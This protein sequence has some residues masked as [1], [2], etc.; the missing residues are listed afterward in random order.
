VQQ[1]D[2]TGSVLLAYIEGDLEPPDF[3]HVEALVAALHASDQ[4]SVSPPE[5]VNEGADDYRTL[6]LV[7]RLPA[8]SDRVDREL[9]AL[10]D[11]ER[12]VAVVEG[13]TISWAAEFAFEL[14]GVVVGWVSGG[15][16]DRLLRDGLIEPWRER[17]AGLG[18]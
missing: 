6:G 5:L 2:G 3:A 13:A 11:V 9:V 15:Q 18:E 17:L 1:A 16:R 14:D 7:L 12:F 8:A 4:W 10:E